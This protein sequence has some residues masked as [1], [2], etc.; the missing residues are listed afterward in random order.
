MSEEE[1]DNKFRKEKRKQRLNKNRSKDLD[2]EK[3]IKL[4]KKG[5][6]RPESYEYAQ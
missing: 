4:P 3:R 6:E 1:F 2:R 5:R